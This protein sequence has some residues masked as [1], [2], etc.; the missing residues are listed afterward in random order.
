MVIRASKTDPTLN[1]SF[2]DYTEARKLFADTARVRTPKDKARVENQV[3][4]V[5]ER[6]FAGEVFT[7][8]LGAIRRHAEVWCRDVAGA[9]V[10][11]STRQVP[12][13]VYERDELPHMQPAPAATFDVPHWC[14]P[15]VHPDHH[16]QVLK[17]LYSVPTHYIGKTLGARADRSSVRLYLGMEIIKMHPRRAAGQ[18]ST[19]PKDFPP[20][21]APWALRDVDAVVRSAREQGAHVGAFIE[22]L[23]GGPVPWIKLRQAYGLLRLCQRYGQDRVNALCARALAFEVID[24]RRIE[25]MLKDARRTEDAAVATG[26]VIAL[27]ARF[28]RDPSAFATRTA[29]GDGE[30]GNTRDGGER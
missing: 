26:R 1:R 3:P 11:G 6:C 21:K 9:R 23:L 5:R 17:A 19:D 27:P 2:R 28:A 14:D 25:G 4:Y 13:E 18:R 16:V 29:V 12:R 7:A 24:V 30:P 22:R 20:G 15:K 8:D 10:H